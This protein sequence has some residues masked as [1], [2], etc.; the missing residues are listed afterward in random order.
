[1]IKRIGKAVWEPYGLL[2]GFYYWERLQPYALV[3]FGIQI[4]TWKVCV[5]KIFDYDKGRLK[6]DDQES[7]WLRKDIVKLESHKEKGNPT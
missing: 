7:H 2:G 3:L 1:M 5:E 6:Y 4:F